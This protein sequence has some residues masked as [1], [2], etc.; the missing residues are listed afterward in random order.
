MTEST[1]PPTSGK[2]IIVDITTE[3]EK[4]HYSD[5]VE[6]KEPKIWAKKAIMYVYWNEWFY[7]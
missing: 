4:D 2:Q 6:E 1:N 5:L 3:N 7:D